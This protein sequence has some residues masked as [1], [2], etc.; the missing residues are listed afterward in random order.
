MQSPHKLILSDQH[1]SDQLIRFGAGMSPSSFGPIN[2]IGLVNPSDWW[3]N[4]CPSKM[5]QLLSIR[6]IR[7]F[8]TIGCIGPT[9]MA[10]DL[11]SNVAPQG[12]TLEA[13]CISGK[14]AFQSLYA[15]LSVCPVSSADRQQD[16]SRSELL[17]SKSINENFSWHL[18]IPLCRRIS[19]PCW[20]ILQQVIIPCYLCNVPWH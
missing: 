2:P 8:Q 5:V 10:I 13:N 17:L 11:T 9:F 18:C 3:I 12:L 15:R 1:A 4:R 7:A 6:L 19:L 16:W 20:Y 14:L